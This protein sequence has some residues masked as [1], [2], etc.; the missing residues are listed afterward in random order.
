M[1]CSVPLCFLCAVSQ[2]SSACHACFLFHLPQTFSPLNSLFLSVV[3]FWFSCL[4]W[5]SLGLFVP[6]LGFCNFC[7]CGWFL[8]SEPYVLVFWKLLNSAYPWILTH[9]KTLTERLLPCFKRE[10]INLQKQKTKKKLQ[11]IKIICSSHWCKLSQLHLFQ[12]QKVISCSCQ[13][14]SALPSF[15]RVHIWAFVGVFC[16]ALLSRWQT[17]T[18]LA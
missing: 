18:I 10:S 6:L 12:L 14:N 4:F 7:Y 5:A 17:E 8:F 11:N 2:S 1:L 15:V 13:M 3:L 16:A 9:P